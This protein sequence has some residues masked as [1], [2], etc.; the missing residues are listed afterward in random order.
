MQ[1]N[2]ITLAV[3]EEN[4]GVGL[5]N[6]VYTR[7][8][9]FQNRALYISADHTLNAKDTLGFYRTFPK[10]SG[11][12]RGVAKTS[13]KFSKDVS[14]TGVDGVSS[15]LAPI[16]VEVSVSLPVGTTAADALIARQRVIALL[17]R[18]DVMVPLME[19][20]MV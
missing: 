4:D 16:I 8:E 12:F 3:D 2:T 13:T 11:N 14:V 1:P 17:D 20:Q 19:Q 15:I 18:D 10:T 9:E 5:V 7:F 6:H